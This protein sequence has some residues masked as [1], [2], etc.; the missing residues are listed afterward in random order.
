MRGCGL[1]QAEFALN[2]RKTPYR[3]ERMKAEVCSVTACPVIVYGSSFSTAILDATMSSP[4][5][6][7]VMTLKQA[8]TIPVTKQTAVADVLTGF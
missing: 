3:I 7:S 2:L 6:H 8:S 4:L 1:R 5:R